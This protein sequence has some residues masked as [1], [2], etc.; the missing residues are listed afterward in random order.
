VARNPEKNTAVDEVQG[1]KLRSGCQEPQDGP[2]GAA[3]T[4][5]SARRVCTE[6]MVTSLPAA[7]EQKSYGNS[8]EL[9]NENGVKTAEAVGE[10]LAVTDESTAKRALEKG[11]SVHTT[12]RFR[13]VPTLR[14]GWRHASSVP[15]KSHNASRV[16]IS[17]D[18]IGGSIRGIM[19]GNSAPSRC[20]RS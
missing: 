12:V 9:G 3:E 20:R 4:L 13:D 11:P 10:C 14:E 8:T 17:Q 18:G 19:W 1:R 15:G 16:M 2:N 7:D 6:K 5:E